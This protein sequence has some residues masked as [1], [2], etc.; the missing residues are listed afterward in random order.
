MSAGKTW[1]WAFLILAIGAVIMYRQSVFSSPEPRPTT[2]VAFI[3]GGA[4]PYW[5]LTVKG[6]EQAAREY[7]AKL[8]VLIPSKEED[9]DEQMKLLVGTKRDNCDGIAI[10]PL[11]AEAQTHIINQMSD[12]V[13]VV[14]FDSDAPLSLRRFHIGTSN[15]RAGKL[16]HQLLT[17]AMGGGGEVVILLANLTKSNMIDRKLGFEEANAEAAEGGKVVVVDE[18]IDK[19]DHDTVKANIEQALQAHPNLAGIVAMNGYHGP[20]L[21]ELRESSDTLKEKK[22]VTFDTE[23]ATLKGLE[24]DAIY[25][26]IAQDPYMFGYEAVRMLTRLNAGKQTTLPIVGGGIVSVPCE[27]LRKDAVA[28][29]RKRMESRSTGNKPTGNNKKA[30]NKAADNDKQ[31]EESETATAESATAETNS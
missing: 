8:Q 30:T 10:S 7:D 15:Y 3:T 27:A 25:G 16:C 29:F 1:L 2:R 19:G 6:A 17:E 12:D 23:P 13:S 9:L 18:L 26:T 28:D 20:L 11:D 5:D 14:T 21:V 22:L 4:G 24:T 31:T